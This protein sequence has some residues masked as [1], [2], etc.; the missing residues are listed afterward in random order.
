[1]TVAELIE[2]LMKFPLDMEVVTNDYIG[3]DYADHAPNPQEVFRG[4]KPTDTV[5]VLN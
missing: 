4:P 5:V 3:G 1:M 2:A